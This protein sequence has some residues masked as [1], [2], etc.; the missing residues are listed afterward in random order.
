M[1]SRDVSFGH[2]KLTRNGFQD[3]SGCLHLT[4]ERGHG[5]GR[6]ERDSY[7]SSFGGIAEES[8]SGIA[9]RNPNLTT[10]IGEKWVALDP[11]CQ[12]RSSHTTFESFDQR[13]EEREEATVC[14]LVVFRPIGSFVQWGDVAR[15]SYHDPM[16]K[17]GIVIPEPQW[18][19]AHG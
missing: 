13:E 16:G 6:F 2:M 9:E 7:A 4:G 19:W 12:D 17:S 18:L 14:R 15:R 10:P 5:T 3:V 1:M 8:R 11:T